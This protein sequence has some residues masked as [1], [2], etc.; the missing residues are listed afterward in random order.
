VKV[1][2]IEAIRHAIVELEPRFAEYVETLREW[3]QLTIL[4]VESS[5]SPRW[6]LAPAGSAADW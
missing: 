2:G 4:S 5:R 6:H 3:Q 1:T